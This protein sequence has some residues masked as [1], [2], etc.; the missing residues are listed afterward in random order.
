MTKK[1]CKVD[2]LYQTTT[3]KKL[4]K[5]T[6][7]QKVKVVEILIERIEKEGVDKLDADGR[8]KYNDLKSWF[9]KTAKKLRYI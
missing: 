4:R 2:L 9:E 5:M 8:K 7:I 6:Q 3:T 1:T